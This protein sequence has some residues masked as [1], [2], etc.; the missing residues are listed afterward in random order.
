MG[1]MD[2]LGPPRGGRRGQAAGRFR[3]RSWLALPL[4]CLLLSACGQAVDGAK[5]AQQKSPPPSVTVAA[6]ERRPITDST[7][8]TGRVVAVDTVDLRARVTGFLEQ[9]LFKE[10]QNVSKGDLL[11]VIEKAPFQAVV[12]QQQ[13]AVAQAQAD[14]DNANLQLK[15]AMDL[16]RNRNIAQ[17]TVDDRQAEAASAKA[18][19]M[20]NQAAL[21]AAQINLGYTEIK[22]PIAGRI[23][24][25]IYT[26]GNLV[27]PDRGVLATIVSQDPIYVSFP[28]SSRQLLEARRQ[29]TASGLDPNSFVVRA[30]LP[31]GSLYPHP[32]KVDFLDI[33]VD[34]GTD[35]RLVRALF[36]N[37]DRL[38]VDGQ[39]VNVRV[40]AAQP[41]Q[42]VVVPQAALQFAQAGTS[43]LVVGDDNKVQQRQVR[44][45]QMVGP[46]VVIASGLKPGERVIVEGSQKAK[47]GQVVAP[48]LAA[49]APQA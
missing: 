19:L 31:D 36:P 15:R 44:T 21:H 16:V 48:A 42:V 18:R 7:P 27:G 13:A 20:Q 43:V 24:Q 4:A 37:P 46:D 47:P 30:M 32:G 14:L 6:A 12:E 2:D 11:L 3:R 45:G 1:S 35:T 38:L 29:A 49:K 9:R 33:R 34:R 17:S 41:Q 22:T 8:F 23:G 26:V 40:E 25:S 5:A 10:G 39:F 28:V